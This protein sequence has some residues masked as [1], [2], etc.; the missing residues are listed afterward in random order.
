MRNP[1]EALAMHATARKTEE[2]AADLASVRSIYSK[3]HE[4]CEADR[5]ETGAAYEES[6]DLML[7][8]ETLRIVRLDTAAV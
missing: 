1:N 6:V 7:R 8:F 3:I 5:I 4:G 2:L